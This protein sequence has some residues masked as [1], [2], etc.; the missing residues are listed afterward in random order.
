MAYPLTYRAPTGKTLKAVIKDLETSL[1]WDQTN[2]VWVAAE[3]A[4]CQIAFTEGSDLGFYTG[5]GGLTPVKGGLYEIK[6]IDSAD[7]DYAV[8][9][10]EVFSSLSKT[11]LQ[12]VNAVQT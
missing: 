7:A 12:I 6:V 9:T 8:I 3:T 11:V 4:A 2:S 1:F 10:K 5:T